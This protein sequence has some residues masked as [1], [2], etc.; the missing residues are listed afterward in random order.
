MSAHLNGRTQ[1]L[2]GLC[3]PAPEWKESVVCIGTFDGVH[4]GHREV[5]QSAIREARASG[6][7]CGVVT[8]NRHPMEVIAPQS[9]P[10][11]LI[12]FGEKLRLLQA[13]GP[14]FILVLLFDQA[15][16]ELEPEA[17]LE[18][19]L[20]GRARAG[21]VVVGDD[22]AMGRNRRGSAEWLSSHIPTQ[23]V[24]PCEHEGMRVSSS[25]IRQAILEGKVELANELLGRRFT[26]EGFV[27]TGDQIGRTLGYP[28]ANLAR[29]G[30]LIQ[31]KEGVYVALAHTPT[32]TYKCALSIG[33]RPT[34]DTS[35]TLAIEAFLLDYPGDSL[36]GRLIRIELM[37]YL[38]EQQ[39][40]ES[41]P[42][43]QEQIARDVEVV[44]RWGTSIVQ[45]NVS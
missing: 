13:L 39:H 45:E 11:A 15:L 7:P 10:P 34:V 4:R 12:T 24:G 18:N 44:Q 21:Q 23:I 32:G 31:P 26:L 8:F 36:Y 22:F 1:L 20:I 30:G 3:G 29:L 14:E 41:L 28:T 19:I 40:F 33:T 25:M 43:L 42:A 27:T 9:A 17:F 38:R 37:H 6:K 16:R 5:I 2:V 35:E